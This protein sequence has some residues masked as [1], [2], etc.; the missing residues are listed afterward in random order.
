[1]N[2]LSKGIKTSAKILVIAMLLIASIF[3]LS[4]CK[5]KNKKDD[6]DTQPPLYE[7]SFTGNYDWETYDLA[8]TEWTESS[9]Q[10]FDAVFTL[11]GIVPYDKEFA[12]LRG[13]TD[14]RLNFALIRFSSAQLDK[15]PY[16]EED[17]T[18]FYA[19]VTNFFGTDNA[20]ES[21]FHDIGF[22]S[23]EEASDYLLYQG[24]DN[25]VR[26]MTVE[27]S[28]DGTQENARIFKFIID[29]QNY[30]L[31]SDIY[32]VDFGG[33]YEEELNSV[34]PT[35][36]LASYEAGF[37]GVYTLM[38]VVPYDPETA[39]DLGYTDG[40]VNFALIRF[41][42][43]I[44]KVPYDSN[45]GTGIYIKVTNYYGTE[46]EQTVVNHDTGFSSGEDDF[47]YLLYQGI[48]DT[49]RTM[50]VEISFDGTQEN[51]RIYK[52]IIDPANYTLEKDAMIHATEGSV[53]FN[54]A[55]FANAEGFSIDRTI[56]T[57]Y[58]VSGN[59]QTMTA[60]QAQAYWAD[61]ANA[62]D[63]FIILTLNFEANSTIKYGYVQDSST[64]LGEINDPYVKSFDAGDKTSEDF[65]LGIG[66]SNSQGYTMWRVE[67][68]NSEGETISY[69]VDLSSLI[70]DSAED[71]V[72]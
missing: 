67:V 20:Q 72:L 14:G 34:Q 44:I 2:N 10:G 53:E 31:E 47:T 35:S 23:N 50:T 37:D 69:F 28:F 24:I 25:Q 43:N 4:A 61:E 22:S 26:T 57:S 39:T 41:Q 15:V 59:A 3:V 36:W 6:P 29:P 63:R 13:Y 8:S 17:G 12:D 40:R 68:T 66:F 7:I 58:T 32:T 11:T 46:N 42:S 5:D 51:A 54:G 56:D 16:N 21:V 9:E 1:M 64:E 45:T 27:I 60:E 33:N 48:D 52:F 19:K 70:D 38:D 55:T 71:A 18:G 65:V 49:V 30:Q 62:G